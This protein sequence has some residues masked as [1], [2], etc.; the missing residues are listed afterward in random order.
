VW[1]SRTWQGPWELDPKILATLV[2]WVIYL[3]LFSTRVS[4]SWR[5]RRAAY[6]AIFGF[7]AVLVTFLG[8]TFVSGQHGFLP[9][10]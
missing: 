7:A 8:V 1:A 2:T 9:R 3:T 5:G 4:G 10:P 6:G